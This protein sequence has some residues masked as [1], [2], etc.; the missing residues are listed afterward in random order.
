MNAR[1]CLAAVTLFGV[2]SAESA[3]SA[4]APAHPAKALFLTQSKGYL[5]SSVNRSPDSRE[6]G[7]RR[8]E[9]ADSKANRNRRCRRPKSP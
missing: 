1:L 4:D 2:F 8:R 5:H 7:N 6:K 3:F 9:S